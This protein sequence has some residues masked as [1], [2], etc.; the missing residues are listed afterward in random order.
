M[1][2]VNEAP[3]NGN[4]PLSRAQLEAKREDALLKKA[5]AEISLRQYALASSSLSADLIEAYRS[6]Y[7]AAIAE[8]QEIEE[9]LLEREKT[10]ATA[11]FIADS[12]EIQT[13]EVN[14]FEKSTQS[15]IRQ[16]PQPSPLPGGLL[17]V[18][19]LAEA[20]IPEPLKP[21]LCDIAERMQC[22]LEF[23]TVG[24]LVSF[25][26]LVG[27]R[28]GI[29]PKQFDD[30]LVIPNLWGAVIGRPGIMKSPALAE[31]MKPLQRLEIAAREVH[32]EQ[33]KNF[34]LRK[35][36]RKAQ[37]DDLERRI[38]EATKKGQ[39]PE[40]ITASFAPI[41]D[42][43]EPCLCRYIVNDPTVEKLGELL[44]QNPHGL[45]LFRDE[46]TGWLR[47][48]ERD[49]HE[50][51]RAFYLESWNGNGAYTYD[52]IGRGTLH[53]K[54][55]CVSILG[56]I[57]PGPLSD[58]LRSAMRGGSGDDGLMQRFQLAVY[59]DDPQ[60]W[61]NVD[62]WPNTRARNVVFE[63]FEKVATL[64]PLTIGCQVSEAGEIPFFRFTSDAQGFFDEWRSDLEQRIRSRDEHPVMEAHLAKFR[65]LQPSLALLFH[66]LDLLQEKASGAISKNAAKMSAA[67]CD[68][69]ESHARRI[70]QGLTQHSI[71]SARKL[72]DRIK[73]YALPSPFT[74]GAVLRK[75]WS[76]LTT[77]DE[78]R[79]AA[80]LLEELNWIRAERIESGE[81][82]GRPRFHYLVH[83]NLTVRNWE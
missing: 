37:R 6:D 56:G 38:R 69:L 78:V 14:K 31:V 43:E 73:A 47:T 1:M 55:A 27:R 16:W 20:M 74:L 61:R 9:A 65:S 83:P 70:Y 64:N 21:W 72:A 13:E 40:A 26:G 12:D 46:L 44:N 71:F 35:L 81:R 22:P 2:P 18:P 54:A 32:D 67:W 75:G 23:P 49:G 76:G 28:V 77:L 34:G 36:V 33:M 53:I 15:G 59:P 57:Q 79:Q 39:D 3:R 29:R 60:G 7:R 50:N 52:R 42:E 82:G 8:L 66:L 19:V 30:W 45:L 63:L 48:L 24:A 10:E 17:P 58:Y 62:Q 5:A 51:D 11:E 4:A 25:A 41:P 68:F 80:D